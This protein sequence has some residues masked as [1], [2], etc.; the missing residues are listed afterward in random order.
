[1][2]KLLPYILMIS[3]FYGVTGCNTREDINRK[4]EIERAQL[5]YQKLK[6]EILVLKKEILRKEQDELIEGGET[7]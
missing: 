6:N 4:R 2:K 7:P 3:L 1:M 5:E